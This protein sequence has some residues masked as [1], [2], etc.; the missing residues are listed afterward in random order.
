MR[1]RERKREKKREKEKWRV[2]NTFP[3]VQERMNEAVEKA[4]TEKE[5][6]KKKRRKK[7][8]NKIILCSL[9]RCD[10]T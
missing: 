8:Q 5:G 3:A 4:N 6:E 9:A 7:E 1:Y 10:Q 2:A